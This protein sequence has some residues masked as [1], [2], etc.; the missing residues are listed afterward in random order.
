MF[1]MPVHAVPKPHSEKLRFINNHSAGSFSLNIMIDKRSVGM[2][3]DN[4]QDLA[5]NLLHFRKSFANT[6]VHLSK[7]DI[8][9]HEDGRTIVF[10]LLGAGPRMHTGYTSVRIPL[11]CK[12]FSTV[13]SF[14]AHEVLLHLPSQHHQ[15]PSPR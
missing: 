2:R 14:N 11:C 13:A 4:V 12:H 15:P 3:P 6:P 5:H 7:S 8:S 10:K 9:L 1:S